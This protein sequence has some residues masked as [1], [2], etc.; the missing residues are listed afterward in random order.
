VE[1]KDIINLELYNKIFGKPIQYTTKVHDF[2][3]TPQERGRIKNLHTLTESSE[4]DTAWKTLVNGVSYR[5][6]YITRMLN[7]FKLNKVTD[8]DQ[9]SLNSKKFVYERLKD[10]VFNKILMDGSGGSLY[11]KQ[12]SD[13]IV[14][15][16]SLIMNSI[17]KFLLLTVNDKTVDDALE[18]ID[19]DLVFDEL[20]LFFDLGDYISSDNVDPYVDKG[21]RF[22]KEFNESFDQLKNTTLNSVV[23]TI[24]DKV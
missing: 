5:S 2:G 13:F 4:R 12:V 15:Q 20:K 23:K 3:L 19:M 8:T 16:V 9:I 17:N 11:A 10:G 7:D 1:N 6:S 21:I 24:K 14:S 18:N 22:S